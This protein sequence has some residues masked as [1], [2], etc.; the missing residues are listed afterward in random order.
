MLV[1]S[2]I[3]PINFPH[4]S[5]YTFWMGAEEV[6]KKLVSFGIMDTQHK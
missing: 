3:I 6:P 2:S 5:R 4:E 1:K